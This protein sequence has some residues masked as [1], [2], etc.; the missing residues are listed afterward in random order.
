MN[1]TSSD[2]AF[3]HITVI[4][5]LD[6]E[7]FQ[8][9][10]FRVKNGIFDH[11]WSFLLYSVISVIFDDFWLFLTFFAI[12]TIFAKKICKSYLG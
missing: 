4:F 11:F 12:L 3:G 2:M 8:I 5:R 9:F 6:S 1:F 10:D 7:N